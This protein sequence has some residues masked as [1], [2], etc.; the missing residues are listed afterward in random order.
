MSTPRATHW[1]VYDDTDK[2]DDDPADTPEKA[3]EAYINSEPSE[4]PGVITAH[5]F[6]RTNEPL[7]GDQQFDGYEPG[8][9]YFKPTGETIL[10][11]VKFVYTVVNGSFKEKAL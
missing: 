2:W 3:T 9:E 5:G 11:K 6:A 4:A 10:V 1:S 7:E 8:C